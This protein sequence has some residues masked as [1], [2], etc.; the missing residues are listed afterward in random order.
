MIEQ[1]LSKIRDFLKKNKTDAILIK[2][3][4]NVRYLSGFTGDSCYLLIT[5]KNNYFLGDF[6]YILQA[7]NQLGQIFKI[8]KL[9]V[10]FISSIRKIIR[11]EKII[12]L[13]FESAQFTFAQY[14]QMSSGLKNLPKFKLIP[15]K[16]IV[17]KLREIKSDAEIEIIRKTQSITKKSVAQ[18]K[19]FIKIGRTELQIK[20]KLEQILITNGSEGFA[21]DIIVASGP[22][23]A[24]PHA[25]STQRKIRPNEP[26]IIDAGIIFQGYR[27]DL[28]RTFFSGKIT[29]YTK[30]K[31]YYKLVATA[32]DRA[33]KLIRPN[34]MI[35]K[36]DQAARSV[37]KQAR[38]NQYFGHALGHG[39]GLEIH[40]TPSISQKN[41]QR[42]VPG[43][44]FTI[45]PGLYIP[46]FG[47]IRIEDVVLVTK[48]GCEII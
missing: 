9:R 20:Q 29:Q 14:Q 36:I 6:R 17:E 21:F 1:R 38:L 18:I 22:N 8:I 44:I 39:I 30:Y 46:N 4:A 34:V 41:K 27:S 43:M 25:Q 3:A 10:S 2:S 48:K 33:I 40:E 47:G 35:S 12:K 32:Q 31:K 19:S 24:M 42:L 5:L 26:I 37:F 13:N 16:N 23:T 7:N 45:E 11:K 28:T 15:L